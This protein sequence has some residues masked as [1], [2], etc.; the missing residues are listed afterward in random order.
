MFPF[1]G[2]RRWVAVE[3]VQ[4]TINRLSI[5]L[6]LP[7]PAI[8]EFELAKEIGVELAHLRNTITRS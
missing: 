3:V 4:P 7:E 2:C 6:L 8:E 1:T 5:E